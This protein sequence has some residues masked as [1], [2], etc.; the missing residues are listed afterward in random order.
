MKER[1][2]F[3]IDD[4]AVKKEILEALKN[5]QKVNKQIPVFGEYGNVIAKITK[6]D[7]YSKYLDFWLDDFIDDYAT[8]E[9][10][11]IQKI[12][13]YDVENNKG[14]KTRRIKE[15]VA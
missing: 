8:K 6:W 10:G 3:N 14:T 1:L 4:V 13:M 9:P 15:I 5:E 12:V 11:K 2:Y 7:I